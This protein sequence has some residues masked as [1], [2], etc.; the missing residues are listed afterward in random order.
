VNGYIIFTTRSLVDQNIFYRGGG[1]VFPLYLYPDVHSLDKTETRR[2]NLNPSIVRGIAAKTGLVFT[3]EKQADESA[4]API[5]ILNYIY[6]VL[7]SNTYRAKHR[8]FLKIDFPR[9]PYP[10]NAERFQKLA[11]IGSLLRGLHVMEN[12]SPATDTAGFPV[13]GTNEIETVKYKAGNVY[14]NKH[15]YFENVPLEA[16]EYYI[17]G[18]QPAQKWLK[19][20]KGRVLSFED[21]EHYQKIITVLKSTIELQA[22]IDAV[23]QNA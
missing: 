14:V 20:R 1:T 11:S 13:A 4:F 18:Y 15:Q 22:W 21:I 5:D 12:V 19:D 3:A 2:P 7:Y 23:I 16:W 6:A 8:E 9:V 10:E 17:G